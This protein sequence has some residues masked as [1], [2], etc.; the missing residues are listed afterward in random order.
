MRGIPHLTSRRKMP[1][2]QYMW[3]FHIIS[4]SFSESEDILKI[5]SDWCSGMEC[6]PFTGFFSKVLNRVKGVKINIHEIIPLIRLQILPKYYLVLYCP[7]LLIFCAFLWYHRPTQTTVDIQ[8]ADSR[9]LSHLGPQIIRQC[10]RYFFITLRYGFYVVTMSSKLTMLEIH[11]RIS[12][13]VTAS[14]QK[15]P[16]RFEYLIT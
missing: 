13:N 12:L 4:T 1:K 9:V 10:L 14:L 8:S 11:L 7:I 3:K 5:P 15:G 6:S 2:S 16:I